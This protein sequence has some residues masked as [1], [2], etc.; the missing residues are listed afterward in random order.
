MGV[1]IETNEINLTGS[2]KIM[3]QDG[4]LM[5]DLRS[6]CYS[7]YFKKSYWYCNDK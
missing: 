7:P 6:A 4:S 5:G 1:Q 3:N 2:L